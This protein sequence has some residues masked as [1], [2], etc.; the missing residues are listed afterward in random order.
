MK[1]TSRL[2]PSSGMYVVLSDDGEQRIPTGRSHASR[3]LAEQL[4]A[5]MSRDWDALHF[6]GVELPGT[7]PKCDAVDVGEELHRTAAKAIGSPTGH[8]AGQKYVPPEVINY[9]P[10]SQDKF[11]VWGEKPAA[12][13]PVVDCDIG[14]S[15]KVLDYFKRTIKN[16]VSMHLNDGMPTDL[17]LQ[18]MNCIQGDFL[19]NCLYGKEAEARKAFG[20]IVRDALRA[21]D[22]QE[23][24]VSEIPTRA[25]WG[26]SRGYRET[27]EA[28][29]RAMAM[30][31]SSERIS[32][33]ISD[34]KNVQNE[35]M[36][37]IPIERFTKFD[38]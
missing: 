24:P 11:G 29:E 28:K 36:K 15:E 22:L 27:R 7:A 18:Q 20:R 3:I 16:H 25:D 37:Q 31:L 5:F 17:Y 26:K 1:F 4:A 12:Q 2:E 6:A 34:F 23:R 35:V 13:K 30:S 9:P 10:V 38:D 33:I 21:C 19:A 32:G 14:M 8:M